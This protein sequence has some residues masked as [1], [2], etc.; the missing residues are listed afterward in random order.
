MVHGKLEVPGM[1][2]MGFLHALPGNTKKG[3]TNWST[4]SLV[5]RSFS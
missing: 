3:W 4:D 2:V 1:E 5:S